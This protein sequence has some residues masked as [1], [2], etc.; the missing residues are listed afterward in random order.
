[1]TLAPAAQ[2]AASTA[3]VGEQFICGNTVSNGCQASRAS[4]LV[5]CHAQASSDHRLCALEVTA[6]TGNT[7]MTPTPP[8]VVTLPIELD[9][10]NADAVSELLTAKLAPGA[11]VIADMTS[12]TFC[13]SAGV[14]AMVHAWQRSQAEDCDLRLLMLPESE[15]LRIFGLLGLDKALPIY[16][17]LDKALAGDPHSPPD[18]SR[19]QQRSA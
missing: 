12:T 5:G 8:S 14:R 17:S 16:L 3:L 18:N 13:D 6:T 4:S 9:Q 1:M 15:V 7:P 2:A 11:V 19:G 10:V